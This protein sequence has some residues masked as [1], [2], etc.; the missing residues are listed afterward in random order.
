VPAIIDGFLGANPDIDLRLIRYA[1]AARCGCV[2]VQAAITASLPRAGA[3]DSSTMPLTL[4]RVRSMTPAIASFGTLHRLSWLAH[5]QRAA[6]EPVSMDP[7]ERGATKFG[8]A[9][10]DWRNGEPQT[11]Q[12][13][14][15]RPSRLW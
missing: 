6:A 13:A 1:K 3:S 7:A 10:T 11:K 5:H 4:A 9:S 8:N 15:Y 14:A 2:L 12:Q